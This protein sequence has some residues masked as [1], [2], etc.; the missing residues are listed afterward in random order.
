MKQI[1]S[2]LPITLSLQLIHTTHHHKH[3]AGAHVIDYARGFGNTAKEGLKRTTRWGAH[4]FTNK[5]SYYPVP[6]NSISFW[7]IPFLPPLPT[8][9]MD[10]E[11]Q[12]RMR[13]WARNNGKSVRQ[14]TV[15]QETTK[16]KAGTLPLNMY[17]RKQ[18]IGENTV[19]NPF[20]PLSR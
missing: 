6:S 5:K 17:E 1:S 14:R 11:D 8:V 7:D 2:R 15:R 13:E 3:E 18:Q 19:C 16:Y 9:Q 20:C 10:D 4:Y 12:E